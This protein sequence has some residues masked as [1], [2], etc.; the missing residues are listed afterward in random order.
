MDTD[1]PRTPEANEASDGLRRTIDR[2]ERELYAARAERDTHV[3]VT[4]RIKVALRIR[5][6]GSYV[7]WAEYCRE[8]VERA[9]RAEAE[10]AKLRQ[11]LMRYEHAEAA[12]ILYPPQEE[13][14]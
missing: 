13:T 1:T 11:K 6:T 14:K 12:E 7:E 9:E 4:E 5:G 10:L 3:A 2:L 8:S